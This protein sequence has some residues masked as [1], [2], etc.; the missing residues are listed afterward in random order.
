MLNWLGI[1]ISDLKLL[2]FGSVLCGNIWKTTSGLDQPQALN[3]SICV[4]IGLK[5]TMLPDLALIRKLDLNLFAEIG[6]FCMLRLVLIEF[7]AC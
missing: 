3:D 2:V 5:Q 7:R 4:S 1:G 6:R